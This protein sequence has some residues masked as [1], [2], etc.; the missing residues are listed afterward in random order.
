MNVLIVASINSGSMSPFI[1]EQAES[2]SKLGIIVKYFGINGKG[3]WGYLK[4]L[5]SLK[6]IIKAENIDII[7]AHY[8]LSGL[9]SVLQRRVPVVVTFHGSDI[10]MLKTRFFSKLACYLSKYNIFVNQKMIEL[11]RYKRKQN[12][13]I[14]P[15]GINMEIFFPME[16]T[17]ARKILKIDSEK[18]IVL[19]CSSR[20]RPEKNFP[21]AEAA[22]KLLED[23]EIIEL[24][25]YSREQVMVLIN[26]ADVVLMTSFY[27]GSP[28]V[29]KE[30]MA[31]N[32]PIISTDV[33]DVK[34][35]LTNLEGC[36]LCGYDSIEISDKLKLVLEFKKKTQARS[37]VEHLA[38]DLV[39]GELKKIYQNCII[40]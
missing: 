22:V 6:K 23:V 4:N 29:I 10:Q 35:L 1:V 26:A 8:G 38:L 36:Y 3:V 32:V 30:A 27:E 5:R 31:C 19:F 14:L 28:Q 9:L 11:L 34:N 39:A 33:G 25:G 21:L 16:K 37:R 40:T 7:H 17:K 18:K 13:K 24:K 20:T 15:C 2:L 12:Y